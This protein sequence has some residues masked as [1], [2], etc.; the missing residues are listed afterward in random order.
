M[1]EDI[2]IKQVVSDVISNTYFRREDSGELYAAR[3][4]LPS[5]MGTIRL[6]GQPHSTLQRYSALLVI[7]HLKYMSRHMCII[8]S[9]ESS[10]HR[11]LS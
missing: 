1:L 9:Y 4:N 6:L 2:T 3:G 7:L 8:T 5:T 10:Y 11:N